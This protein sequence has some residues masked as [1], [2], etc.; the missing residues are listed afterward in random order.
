[1]HQRFLSCQC[2]FLSV[3]FILPVPV[4]GILSPEKPGTSGIGMLSVVSRQN[5][6]ILIRERNPVVNEGNEISLSAIDFSGQPVT[7]VT[8]ESGSPD[9]A[10]VAPQ[11]GRVTGVQQGFATITARRGTDSVSI[12][13]V[14]TRVG[15]GAGVK[16][17][18]DTR[19]D[20]TGRVYLSDP[21]GNVIFRKPSLT[22]AAEVFAGQKGM[23]GK[24]D[25]PRAQ[26]RFA[27]PTAVAMDNAAKGG[28]YIADTL[29][30]TIRKLDPSEQVTTVLGK[31]SPGIN[32]ADVTPFP[33]AMFNGPRGIVSDTGGNL[34]IADTDN[35]AIFY[36]DFAR[37]EV[38]LLA[39]EPG[40]T[41]KTDGRGRQARFTRPT[42]LSLSADG[43]IVAVADTGNNVVRLVTRD[44]QVVTLGRQAAAR[45]FLSNSGSEFQPAAEIGFSAPQSVCF[46]PEGDIYVVD[47]SG[48]FV[49]TRGIG[50]APQLFALAQPGVSFGQPVSLTVRGTQT[51]VL[52]ANAAT[53]AEA[54]KVVTVGAPQILSL[55]R[56]TDRLEGGSEV[57]ITGKNFAPESQV[58]L[59]SS[60]M[61]GATV[62]NA[63][64]IRFQVPPQGAPGQRTL[65]V[66]TRGGVAQREFTIN[67]K[68]LQELA[69]GE[70]TTIAGGVLYTGDGGSAEN[71][72]LNLPGGLAVDA[73]GNLL[74]V[75]SLDSRVR[76]VDAA[77]VITS[78]A[79]NG[80]AGF[81]GDGGPAIG[82]TLDSPEGIALDQEGNVFIADVFN[83]RIRR[84]DARTGAISTIAGNGSRGFSGDR[85]P[86]TAASLNRPGGVAVDLAGNVFIADSFNDRVRRVDAVTGI[87]TTIAGNGRFGFSGD[88]GPATSAAL[89]TPFEVIFDKNQNLLIADV[90]NARVRSVDATTGTITTIA[91]NGNFRFSGD[92]GVATSAGVVPYRL[93]LDHL[94]NLLI[95][96]IDNA[97]IRRVDTRTRIISTVAGNG[98]FGFNGDG[99]PATSARISSPHAVTADGGGN[100][101]FADTDNNRIRMVDSSGII[102]TVVGTTISNGDNGPAINADLA[103]PFGLTVD[104]NNN[105]LIAGA[106]DH[107]IRRVDAL[108]GLISTVAGN[109]VSGFGGDG[110][111]ATS[112]RLNFPRH[113]AFDSTGNLYIADQ[114][115]FRVRRV[116]TNGRIATVAGT[117]NFGFNDDDIPATSAELTDI[118]AVAL[119]AAGNLLIVDTSS[120]LLRRVDAA[121]GRIS[122]LAGDGS[123][124]FSGDG[125][126]S[127]NAT[128]DFFL[129]GG[130]AVDSTGNIFIADSGNNRIRRID[131]QTG[132]ITTVAGN[133]LEKFG[134]D[135]GPAINASL[136][137]PRGVFVDGNNNL[138]IVDTFNNRI[139][140]LDTQTGI[141]TTVAGNG[142]VG[143][144]GDGGSAIS[145]S[146]AKPNGVV[147]DKSG[148]LLIGDTFNNCVR[149]V[150][151]FT[152]LGTVVDF[153][154][155]ASPS[156]QTVASGES[157][158]FTVMAPGI[159]GFSQPVGLSAAI[160]PPN[161]NVSVSF[162][163]GTVAP[164][165]TATLTVSTTSL[166]PTGTYAV[167]VT[168]T[169]SS[170]IHGQTVIVNVISTNSAPSLTPL[171]DQTVQAGEVR[172]I[173]V[174]ASDPD[175]DSGLTLS[176]AASPTYVTLTDSGNGVGTIR[177]APTASETQSG[178]IVVQ[179]K[180]SGGLVA[181]TSFQVTVQTGGG[182]L[183][184]NATY[185]SPQ[186]VITG[187]GFGASGAMVTING[188]NV[189]KF[190]K[191]QNTTTITLKGKPKKLKLQSGV[192]QI[193]VT[194]GGVKSNTFV[195]TI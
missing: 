182:A 172:M 176:L 188:Q 185:T 118:S 62:E 11:T 80:E 87:I 16:I 122:T 142:G 38:R 51:F 105:L 6:A 104:R 154:V 52:D 121:T 97:R 103:G 31:G 171:A 28:V 21:L 143:Y 130:V 20:S 54:I 189:S 72:R 18:G 141:I 32:T 95:A 128:L 101:Y 135:G 13:V 4:P 94:G 81:S 192:N 139:R 158:S 57:V 35:H 169:A 152:R 107:R 12:F 167:K 88:G 166:T 5:S 14:V 119:D 69:D 177:I 194:I 47:S 66:I 186:L 127:Q 145:A 60:V 155:T 37:Q 115:N 102:T 114:F 55:T 45:E 2:I 195:L 9:I 99:G 116:D 77:G 125:G 161:P 22:A 33:Q 85:G 84:V 98:N 133:G 117:G 25:G 17:Q 109:G 43:R 144:D 48:A 92:G 65:S 96:D 40:V 73:L 162:S 153:G 108:T 120:N 111:M 75:D 46:D 29:N 50:Q 138:L 100:I 149:A 36:A 164:G 129:F 42:G 148:N 79:G 56:D 83:H 174:S 49:V 146:L 19:T 89:R 187:S 53:E 124:S 184:T 110:G 27:G 26:A 159:N 91:G 3:L 70:I 150:K 106:F 179:V 23:S 163:T 160:N 112:A 58:I 93:A 136:G 63:T 61:V 157:T 39:G 68:P 59:G 24:T 156:S 170:Q 64:T 86:A 76:R 15:K 181:Q 190:I 41:G 134:G 71:A 131:G 178:Q 30:H 113:I 173:P 132:I 151:G 74:V 67:A 10:S 44:G 123:A 140:R 193:I 147:I 90:D 137:S 82:A 8:W 126:P 191:S 175:G 168:G 78:I 183:I 7:G 1:M 34:F 165:G 180:D